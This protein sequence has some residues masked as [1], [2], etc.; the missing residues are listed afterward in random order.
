MCIEC[1]SLSGLKLWCIAIW[2]KIWCITF[3]GNIECMIPLFT[4]LFEDTCHCNLVQNLVQYI[5]YLNAIFAHLCQYQTHHHW[6]SAQYQNA[7]EDQS[8]WTRKAAL[9]LLICLPSSIQ[10]IGEKCSLNAN[11]PLSVQDGA[12]TTLPTFATS[13]ASQFDNDLYL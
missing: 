11:W 10:M 4:T 9:I 8:N 2:C 1:E 13:Y 7:M 6:C 12:I 3:G 5:L